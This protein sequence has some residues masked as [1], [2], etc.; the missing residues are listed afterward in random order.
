MPPAMSTAVDITAEAPPL[1]GSH[2][3]TSMFKGLDW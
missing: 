2:L 3:V 1:I